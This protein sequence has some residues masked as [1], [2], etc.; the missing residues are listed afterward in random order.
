MSGWHDAFLAMLA[1]AAAIAGFCALSLAMD[2]HWEQL[3]GRGAVLPARSRR[4]LRHAGTV[5]LLASLAACI[6]LRGTGQGWVA[7]AGMLTAAAVMLVWML[8]YATR[9]VVRLGWAATAVALTA[10]GAAS[11]CESPIPKA[12]SGPEREAGRLHLHVHDVV[13]SRH[14]F[15][16]HLHRRLE[17]NA[18][19]LHGDHGVG[20]TDRVVAGGKA[21]AQV[22]G[23]DLGVADVLQ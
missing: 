14:Q 22:V 10:L 6:A 1:L 8:T 19:L 2:R 20:Q 17:G 9:G 16:P 7:W 3:Q 13:I 18:R 12:P 4:R 15:I 21:L 23:L 11:M 5:G